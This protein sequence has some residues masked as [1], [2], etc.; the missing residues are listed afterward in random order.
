MWITVFHVLVFKAKSLSIF[1]SILL[2]LSLCVST[3]VFL[4]LFFHYYRALGFHYAL[5][6]ID[7]SV[8]HAQTISIGVGQAFLELVPPL[9]YHVYHLSRLDQFLYDHKSNATYVFLQHLSIEHVI[10]IW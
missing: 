8:G 6:P 2:V 9:A 4:D 7:V 10:F 1:L 3:S 5:V